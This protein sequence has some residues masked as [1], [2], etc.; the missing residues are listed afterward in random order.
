MSNIRPQSPHGLGQRGYAAG[1]AR[2]DHFFDAPSSGMFL[3]RPVGK[4][5]DL[6]PS[7]ENSRAVNKFFQENWR[8]VALVAWRWVGAAAENRCDCSQGKSRNYGVKFKAAET[9]EAIPGPPH[10]QYPGPIYRVLSRADRQR[11]FYTLVNTFLNFFCDL[12]LRV[13]APRCASVRVPAHIWK[14]VQ[15]LSRCRTPVH[16]ECVLCSAR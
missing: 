15:S 8:R 11:N 4:A 16:P 7:G 2:V 12:N 3:V 5:P 14:P 1:R 6:A 10:A 9:L 13:V